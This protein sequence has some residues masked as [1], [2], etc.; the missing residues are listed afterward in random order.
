MLNLLK[1]EGMEHEVTIDSAG[2]LSYH[3][4]EL[5]DSRMLAHSAKRGYNLFHLSRPVVTDD[6]ER[7]YLILGMDAR[8]IDDLKDR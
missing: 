3:K 1:K 8:N 2:I 7:F 6:F 5:P 4:G